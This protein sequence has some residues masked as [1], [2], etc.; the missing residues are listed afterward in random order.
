[1]KQNVLIIGCGDVGKQAGIQLQGLGF[2]VY[3]IKRN[4]GG[5]MPFPC[6]AAD[7]GDQIS[8]EQCFAQLP[9][10]I[11]YVIY[12]VAPAARSEEDY[13]NA[14]P[15]GVRNILSWLD[16]EVAKGFVLVTSTAVYHQQKGEW[17]D[18]Y[19]DT[20]PTQFSGRKL[21]EAE[22]ILAESSFK[23]VA[24]RLAG[25]YGPGRDRL[26]RK[27]R[28][29]CEVNRDVPVYSNRIHRDDCA[30]ILRFL[31]QQMESKVELGP[32]Y[33][34]VDS[35]PTEQWEVFSEIAKQIG[36]KGP[37]EN[38]GLIVSGQ[39]KRCS[40][41]LI[42]ELGYEFAFDHFADGYFQV[43]KNSEKNTR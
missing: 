30:G 37:V 34:G 24:L 26:I 31:I 39:N 20:F 9:D 14:Y 6:L 42:K 17:V 41:R 21:L 2:S 36:V 23:G 13:H 22:R 29:G 28:G 33:L 43:I 27:V 10:K 35:N 7:V 18:E 15:L 3:G 4:P 19:S 38:N 32:C 12:T 16:P 8:L 1:M 11:H 25:I 40:N 5:D